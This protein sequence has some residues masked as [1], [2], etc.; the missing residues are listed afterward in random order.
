MLLVVLAN[1]FG[2]N[3]QSQ[4]CLEFNILFDNLRNI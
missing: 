1:K 3:A 2:P 4:L